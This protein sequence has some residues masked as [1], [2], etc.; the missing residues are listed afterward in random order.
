VIDDTALF[1][2]RT[3]ATRDYGGLDTKPGPWRFAVLGA[4]SAGKMPFGAL[5]ASRYYSAMLAAWFPDLNARELRSYISLQAGSGELRSSYGNVD[6]GF[7][8]PA[9]SETVPTVGDA[10]T[11]AGLGYRLLMVLRQSGDQR[12]IDDLYPPVKRA[13]EALIRAP[14]PNEAA[15]CYRERGANAHRVA[16][17]HAVARGGDARPYVRSGVHE[18]SG[19][20]ARRDRENVLERALLA[21][22]FG[23]SDHAGSERW[24]GTDA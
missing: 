12:L 6:A 24:A 8:T 18:S 11:L 17:N 19:C 3:I 14:L 5:G 4:L 2:T 13:T 23:V 16:A 1:L 9:G 21:M 22:C 7:A 20:G 15:G 10:D